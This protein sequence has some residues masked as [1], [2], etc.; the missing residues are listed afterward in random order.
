MLK[1]D[2]TIVQGEDFAQDIYFKTNTNVYSLKGYTAKSQIRPKAGSDELTAE[3]VCTVYPNDGYIHMELDEQTISNIPA[4][5][6]QYDLLL[7]KTK[8]KTKAYYMGGKVY[9]EKHVTES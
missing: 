3:F 6:Y 7:T 2:L 5:V 9:I 1:Y 4:G 8:E